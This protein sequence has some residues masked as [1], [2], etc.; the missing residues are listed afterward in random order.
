MILQIPLSAG[1]S[2]ISPIFIV[3]VILML[4]IIAIS[5]MFSQTLSKSDWNAFAMVELSELIKSIILFAFIV[6]LY[7]LLSTFSVYFLNA[8]T[9]GNYAPGSLLDITSV[10]L[11]DAAIMTQIT[12]ITLLELGHQMKLF[13]DA[14]AKVGPGTLHIKFPIFAGVDLLYN[15]TEL[16]V[17]AALTSLH[18][19]NVQLIVIQ[20]INLVTVYLLFPVGLLLR[21]IPTTR[22]SGNELI[23]LGIAGSIILPLLYILFYTITFDIINGHAEHGWENPMYVK[24]SNEESLENLF[25]GVYEGLLKVVV[26]TT[27]FF[28]MIPYTFLKILSSIVWLLFFSL[29]IPTFVVTIVA[30]VT[31]ALRSFLDFDINL[32]FMG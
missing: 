11:R 20:L 1:L 6:G 15:S 2:L 32:G 4:A 28:V 22:N 23:A 30:S 12:Y 24:Y 25:H 18:S 7:S 26:L 9:G 8:F 19:L 16:L 5:Y 3:V 31:R 27:P 29:A 10:F 21:V 14:T 17:I 13:S